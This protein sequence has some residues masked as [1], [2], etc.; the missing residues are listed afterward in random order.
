MKC[1]N[2]SHE[3]EGGNFCEICGAQLVEAPESVAQQP[4]RQTYESTGDSQTEDYLKKTKDQSKQ[5]FTYFMDVL[6]KPYAS[7]HAYMENQHFLYAIITFILYCLFIPLMIYFGVKGIISSLGSFSLGTTFDIT[8]PF[9]DVVIKPFFAFAIF[10]VLVC[11]FTF[12]SIKLGRVNVT[13]K[14]V[15][16]RFGLLLIPF[17]FILTIGLVLSIL[18]VSLFVYFLAI[19]LIGS[20]YIAVPVL[21]TFYRKSSPGE[22]LD[23]VYGTLLTYI[24][25]FLVILIM[26][27]MLF[28]SL[29]TTIQSYIGGY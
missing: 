24:L 19:G 22:G 20:I 28:D 7:L 5:Y 2:C 14:E 1:P 29:I 27:E 15:F 6:K 16:S 4:N 9:M 23:A 8:L 18:E 12:V 26:G 17:V 21:I 3:N 13:F 25:T 11:V 10:M